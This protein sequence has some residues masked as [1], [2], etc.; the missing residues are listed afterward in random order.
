M[1]VFAAGISVAEDLVQRRDGKPGRVERRDEHRRPRLSEKQ[2]ETIKARREKIKNLAEAAR[3]ETDPAK[4]AELTE[5]L[6]SELTEAAKKVQARFRERIEKVE[7]DLET[8]KA[9]LEKAETQMDQRVEEKLQ[10]ILAGEQPGRRDDSSKKRRS[11]GY[12]P[13]NRPAE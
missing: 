10:K 2:R 3:A 6:R 8:M 13:E 5:T 11:K 7:K 1:V 9:R 4:K 12:L